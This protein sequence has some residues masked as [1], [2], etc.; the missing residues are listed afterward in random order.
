MRDEFG[1]ESF[2]EL[3]FEK[4]YLRFFMPEVRSGKIGSKKRYAG[5][6]RAADGSEHIEFVGL[7]SVRRDWSAVSKRFQLGLLERVF[8]DQPVE[9]F[10]RDFLA[11]LRAGQFDAELAYR[12]AVRKDLDA[13]T[14]TT[15]P[16]VRAARK[17]GRVGRSCTTCRHALDRSR[18]SQRRRRRRR[19]PTRAPR[20]EGGAADRRGD[21]RGAGQSFDE[22]IGVPRQPL[23]RWRASITEMPESVPTLPIRSCCCGDRHVRAA[24]ALPS[25]EPSA[26]FCPLSEIEASRSSAFLRARGQR[27]ALAAPSSTTS[28]MV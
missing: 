20:R 15:P 17:A 9:Q 5:L 1:C 13:Y 25:K 3:E 19:S 21:P 23:V 24:L 28:G 12:K 22:V 18:S 14:K 10:V 7:E 27:H 26:F 6:L 4:L 2:L 16:H 8:R 11:D